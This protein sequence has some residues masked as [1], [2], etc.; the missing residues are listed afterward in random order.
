MKPPKDKSELDGAIAVAITGLGGAD[1]GGDA[2]MISGQ[3]KQTATLEWTQWK[4]G[5]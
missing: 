3:N 1:V 2:F 5:L 4:Q